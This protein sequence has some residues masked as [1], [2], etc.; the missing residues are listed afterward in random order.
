MVDIDTAL[1]KL[2]GVAGAFLSLA[3]LRGVEWRERIF[4][5][6]GGCFLS[7]YGTPIAAARSG[8]PEGLTGFLLG[9]FG[10]AICAKFW[11][12]IQ[13]TPIAELWHAGIAKVFGTKGPA[14]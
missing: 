12:M 7:Y 3:F 4:M 13:A 9:L 6:I 8:L 2:A 14:K 1:A 10:M 11:E 5:G